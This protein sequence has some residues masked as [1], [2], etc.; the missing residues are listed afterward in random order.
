MST[1]RANVTCQRSARQEWFYCNSTARISVRPFGLKEFTSKSIGPENR[2]HFCLVMS[3]FERNMHLGYSVVPCRREGEGGVEGWGGGGRGVAD[4]RKGDRRDRHALHRLLVFLTVSGHD[5]VRK[6]F[7]VF[8]VGR[9]KDEKQSYMKASN[10]KIHWQ[11]S[12][13]RERFLWFL[14]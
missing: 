4:R 5:L 10:M 7:S 6:R 9:E 3:F 11:H 14:R 2:S 1:G 13:S 8:E 12:H